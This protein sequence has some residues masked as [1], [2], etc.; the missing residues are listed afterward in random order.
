MRRYLV[1]YFCD[2]VQLDTHTMVAAD[3]D[4]AFE[5]VVNIMEG[6][7][8][9]TLASVDRI[10]GLGQLVALGLVTARAIEREKADVN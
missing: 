7:P 5:R 1:S 4:S 2:R 3:D 10:E 9:M 6:S 8:R